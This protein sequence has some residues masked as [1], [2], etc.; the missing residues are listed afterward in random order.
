M[1]IVSIMVQLILALELS[2]EFLQ[3]SIHSME[4]VIS[5]VAFLVLAYLWP[6]VVALLS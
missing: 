1:V 6:Q 5:F 3:S 4:L 2:K